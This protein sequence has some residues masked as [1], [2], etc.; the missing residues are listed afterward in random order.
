[1]CGVREPWKPRSRS[2]T[3]QINEER[4]LGSSTDFTRLQPGLPIDG[5]NWNRDSV[6]AT[7]EVVAW[8]IEQAMHKGNITKVERAKRMRNSRAALNRLLDPANNAVTLLTLWRAAHA[9][10]R[11]LHI[12][13]V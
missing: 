2:A 7:K 10:G 3:D 9:I 6:I 1:L 13:L 4:L 8:Q 5:V 12:E 11:E